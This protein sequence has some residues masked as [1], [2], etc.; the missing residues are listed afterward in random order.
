[1]LHDEFHEF[2]GLRLDHG[3]DAVEGLAGYG[4]GGGLGMGRGAQRR[5]QQQQA[6]DQS[7]HGEGIVVGALMPMSLAFSRFDGVS[8]RSSRS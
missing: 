4:R 7:V 8:E 1:M 3:N 6:G 5:G 2:T